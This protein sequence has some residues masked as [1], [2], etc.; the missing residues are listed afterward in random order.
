MWG[1]GDYVEGCDGHSP[2]L[3]GG[4]ARPGS[5][6]RLWRVQDGAS[7]HAQLRAHGPYRR[8]RHVD[9]HGS[10][11]GVRGPAL[12]QR[13]LIQLY[14]PCF[15]SDLRSALLIFVLKLAMFGAPAAF[16]HVLNNHISFHNPGGNPAL[17]NA[18]G[19]GGAAEGRRAGRRG[20]GVP[21][22]GDRRL[23]LRA[24]WRYWRGPVLEMLALRAAHKHSPTGWCAPPP[25]PP[26]H[27]T[28][29][30]PPFC[31]V[32]TPSS[33]PQGRACQMYPSSSPW[34]P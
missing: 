28:A 22:G 4:A 9:R 2:G 29:N 20:S 5:A 26:A 11:Q 16:V 24:A 32:S 18:Q 31:P 3:P 7:L 21:Q 1:A 25:P 14:A 15:A 13:G 33:A 23:P 17:V 12:Q 10:G 27:G 30:A 8:L 6:C 19:G 34:T